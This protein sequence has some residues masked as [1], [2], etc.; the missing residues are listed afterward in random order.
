MRLQ[1]YTIHPTLKGYIE[2]LWVFES[3]G[4]V[5]HDDLKLIVPNGLVKLVI[6][7]QNGLAGKYENWFHLSPENQM[8]L[9]GI[10]DQPAWVD[11][12]HDVRSG[13]IGVEFSP[14]GAYRFF[15]L[16]QSAIKN[17]IHPL[18]DVSEKTAR[19]IQEIIANTPVI[20]QKVKLLQQF[21]LSLFTKTAS[22]L[23]LEYCVKRIESTKGGVTIK[24][25]EKETGYS[26]RWLHM[27]FDEKV[28][29]SPKN[30]CAITRFQFYFEALAQN[31]VSVLKQKEFY[32]LY[33]DQAHFTREF[34]RFTGL[35]PVKFA[36]QVNDF[37]KI[38]Y[39]D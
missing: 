28:G 30:L 1:H 36:N 24:R 7:F 15:K 23:I 6:P 20:A 17:Q 8:T 4:R 3:S 11:V 29:I 35:P 33:Y 12:E 31:K 34:K 18:T 37:G 2:K 5:P 26:S 13:T 16:R 22:D 39:K 10:S 9:I 14:L 38:F 21:L 27:K 25:L 19:E 32:H